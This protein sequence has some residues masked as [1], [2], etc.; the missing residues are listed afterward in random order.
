MKNF[1][2]LLENV[3][4]SPLVNSLARQPG[5]WNQNPFRTK[6]PGSPHRE[7]DDIWLRFTNLGPESTVQEAVDSFD[8]IFYPAWYQ[9][10]QVKGIVLDLLRLVEGIELGKILLTKLCPGRQIYKHADTGAYAQEF[11]RYHLS[12]KALPGFKFC[13]GDEE[14]FMKPGDVW[15]FNNKEEHSVINNS[16]DDRLSLI[17]DIRPIR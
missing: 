9:F 3:N 17:V 16:V 10:P 12:L 4:V 6:I 13:C 15:W 5:L 8:N 14:V 7:V 1:H 11:D 2:R